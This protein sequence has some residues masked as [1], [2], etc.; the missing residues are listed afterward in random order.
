[1]SIHQAF[2]VIDQR[3]AER[4]DARAQQA[5]VEQARLE[6]HQRVL[7]LLQ[8][9]Q[10]RIEIEAEAYR[11]IDRWDELRLCSLRY[12]VVWREWLKL[13]LKDLAEVMLQQGSIGPAMRQNSPFYGPRYRA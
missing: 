3:L 2:E 12:V 4:R 1:M 7:A 13:P 9:P 10:Q 5:L 11:E 8:D 6:K